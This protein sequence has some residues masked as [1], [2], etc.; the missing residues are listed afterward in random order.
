MKA[1]LTNAHILGRSALLEVWK[2]VQSEICVIEAAM[3][4]VLGVCSHLWGDL[5]RDPWEIEHST[6]SSLYINV[7]NRR[8][9]QFGITTSV[10]SKMS[11]AVCPVAFS[12]EEREAVIA[13]SQEWNESEESTLISILKAGLSRI[14]LREQSRAIASVVEKWS[15]KQSQAN[16]KFAGTIGRIRMSRLP[17]FQ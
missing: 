8:Q 11:S 3:A 6:H 16:R 7:S 17:P 14:T 10:W 4:T 5:W 15:G 9:W 13:E 12:N 2:C 1:F